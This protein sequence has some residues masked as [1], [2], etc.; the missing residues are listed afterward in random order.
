MFGNYEMH[1][2]GGVNPPHSPAYPMEWDA[3]IRT[4]EV[5]AEVDDAVVD[6][7]ISDTPFERVGS[8]VA[9]RYMLSPWHSLA[10]HAGG[11][12]DLMITV[13]VR[14]QGL[15]TQTHIYMYCT[16]P[17]GIVAGRE[18]FGY[19]KKECT[20]LYRETLEGTVDGWLDRRGDRLADFSFVAD[21]T[22]PLVRLVD[23][24]EQPHGEVH[25]RRLPDPASPVAAYA[26]VVYRDMPIEYSTP[27]PGHAQM[28]LHPSAFDPLHELNPTILGAHHMHT[29]VFGGG[30]A[31]EDR[32]ILTRLT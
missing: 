12:F 19:T 6:A 15:F 28:T 10:I 16:D 20:H 8:R 5:I 31:V 18:L 32:R 13:P 1:T 22:A 26:D 9:F 24:D 2:G 4:L 14:Y 3:K 17:M 27:I 21:A 7:I 30:F 23:G 25:V 11:L 29:E